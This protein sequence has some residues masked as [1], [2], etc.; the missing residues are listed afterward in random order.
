MWCLAGGYLC[1]T[2]DGQGDSV[3]DAGRGGAGA[4]RDG[5]GAGIGGRVGKALTLMKIGDGGELDLS[6]GGRA[7]RRKSL[8]P[9]TN[10][11]I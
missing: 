4:H 3:G 1:R 2:G 6:G 9:L 10:A 11:A 5:G 7:T 8:V